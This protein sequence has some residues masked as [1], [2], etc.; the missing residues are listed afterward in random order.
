MLRNQ[1]LASLLGGASLIFGGCLGVVATASAGTSLAAGTAGGAGAFGSGSTKITNP[2]LPISKFHRT[3]LRGTD[4][5]QHIRIVRTLQHRT[6]AFPYHGKRVRAAVVKDVVTN[7]KSH[8]RIERTI[9]YFAQDKAG[10][11]YY[12]GEDVNEYRRHKPV[13]HEGQWRLGRDTKTP[14]VLM[15]A[16]VR[17]GESYRA[18]AVPGITREIDHIVAVRRTE[19]VHGHSYHHV[20]K[21]RENAGPPP[22]VEFKTYAPGTGVLTEA[23]GGVHLISSG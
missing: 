16:H 9:D 10:T 1:K 17:L 6:K 13:S 8:R 23:N 4:T 2:Y 19:Q 18:E 15:P 21:V 7:L 5:G 11:V 22:E 12:F 20:I 3:V 14:G